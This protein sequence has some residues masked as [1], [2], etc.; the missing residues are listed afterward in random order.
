MSNISTIQLGLTPGMYDKHYDTIYEPLKS[1]LV[2]NR[3]LWGND[4]NKYKDFKLTFYIVT[5][6]GV[7]DLYTKGPSVSKKYL[8]VDYSIFLPD[9][10]KDLNHYIDLVFEGVGIVLQK[11]GVQNSAIEEMKNECKKE[12]EL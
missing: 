10:I 9:E 12:L 2:N 11:Y 6:K 5:K 8:T 7:D 4:T 1:I 3:N